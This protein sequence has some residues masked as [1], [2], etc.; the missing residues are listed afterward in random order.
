MVCTDINVQLIR[1]ATSEYDTSKNIEND[2]SGKR[3][4]ICNC[5]LRWR[6]SEVM[7]QELVAEISERRLQGSD[8]DSRKRREVEPLHGVCESIP[9]QR[10]TS[11]GPRQC[12]LPGTGT[13]G[14]CPC[15]P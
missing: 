13:R 11:P 7:I 2:I 15:P 4:C 12:S 5:V 6:A 9:H 8:V 10:V 1:I 3:I 14:A